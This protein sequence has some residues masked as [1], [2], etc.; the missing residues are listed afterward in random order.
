MTTTRKPTLKERVKS[1]LRT[2]GISD[3]DLDTMADDLVDTIG[4]LADDPDDGEE[5]S[6]SSDWATRTRGMTPQQRNRLAREEANQEM[7]KQRSGRYGNVNIVPNPVM[8]LARDGE[9]GLSSKRLFQAQLNRDAHSRGEQPRDRMA[10]TL[11]IPTL[12]PGLQRVLTL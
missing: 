10:G 2:D 5:R 12:Q 11:R 7:A 6:A 3:A 1:W 4:D 9:E 8:T